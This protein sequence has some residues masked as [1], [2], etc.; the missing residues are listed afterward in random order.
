LA[1]DKGTDRGAAGSEHG[2]NAVR[3]RINSCFLTEKSAFKLVFS[4]LIRVAKRWRR[5][6]FTKTELNYLDRI[7]EELG[8]MEGLQNKQELQEVC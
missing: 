5:V 1:R 6:S 7:R 8:I 4:V 3:T 2:R